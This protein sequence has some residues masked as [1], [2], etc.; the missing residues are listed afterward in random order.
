MK[1]RYLIFFCLLISSL[2]FSQSIDIDNGSWYLYNMNIDGENY[3][4]PLNSEGTP[5]I[6]EFMKNANGRFFSTSICNIHEI[7]FE[8]NFG[9]DTSKIIVF[10]SGSTLG[11]C[12]YASSVTPEY[13]R[14]IEIKFKE[15][16]TVL[17]NENSF[18][19][20]IDEENLD[21]PRQLDI[22]APNGDTLMY[23]YETLSI[24]KSTLNPSFS[25]YPTPVKDK[26]N[27]VSSNN[28]LSNIKTKIFDLNG[29]LVQENVLNNNKSINVETLKKGFYF[30]LIEDE[31]GNIGTQKFVK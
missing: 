9:L 24:S 1:N 31:K 8:V 7:K 23:F 15:F 10:G 6:S 19:Y 27:I 21:Q 3:N 18:Y 16:F 20:E 11:D 17:S 28:N 30:I 13:I 2:G 29:K 12:D 22:T 25:I 26:L 5:I 14:D 4:L